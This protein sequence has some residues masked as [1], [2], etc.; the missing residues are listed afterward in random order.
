MAILGKIMA[1]LAELHCHLVIFSKRRRFF[2]TCVGRFIIRARRHCRKHKTRTTEAPL[3]L[4]VYHRRLEMPLLIDHGEECLRGE[5]DPYCTQPCTSPK[6]LPR[7]PS[8]I[9]AQPFLGHGADVSAQDQDH[10]HPCYIW[11]GTMGK[12]TRGAPRPW[13]Q[14]QRRE[15]LG[16]DPIAPTVTSRRLLQRRWPRICTASTG[17]RRG[18]ECT[19]QGPYY[20]TSPFHM[21]SYNGNVIIFLTVAQMLTMREGARV[22]EKM[23]EK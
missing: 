7:R 17:A 3:H 2:R 13:Y 4:Q 14:S 20:C 15:C 9:L 21:A 12:I 19:R 23:V 5:Q 6:L 18:C 16:P 1:G 8:P 22:T 11:Q 10:I